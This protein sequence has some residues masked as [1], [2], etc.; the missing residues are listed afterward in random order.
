MA[1]RVENIY[2]EEAVLEDKG[3][4]KQ[5]ITIFHCPRKRLG[6]RKSYIILLRFV[7]YVPFKIMYP[8][9]I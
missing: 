2:L 3:E 7:Y 4:D 1:L 8:I 5:G 9:L 6:N